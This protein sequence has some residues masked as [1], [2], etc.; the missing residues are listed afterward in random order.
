MA[1][2]SPVEQTLDRLKALRAA[3]SSPEFRKELARALASR[4][5]YLAIKAAELIGELKV[6]DL[7][8]D[9]AAAF[10]RYLKDPTFPDQ[11]CGAKTA[12]AKALLDTGA[13]GP[14]VTDVYVAGIRHFQFDGPPQGGRATDTAGAL[15]GYCGLGLLS[16]RHPD[17][18]TEL[19]D[20][21]LDAEL[22]ARIGAARGLAGSG[23]ADAA[24]VLRLRL[25]MGDPS[26]DV[27]GECMAGLLKLDPLRSV[28]LV[29]GFLSDPR[30]QVRD[31][32]ALALGESRLSEAFAP[33]RR[34][35]EQARDPDSRATLLL[36]VALLRR[37]ESVELLLAELKTVNATGAPGLIEALRIYRLDDAVRAKAT[38]LIAARGDESLK[39]AFEAAFA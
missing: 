15:R 4:T 12:V 10:H 20:L 11:G 26:P 7:G 5:S 18:V 2:H 39:R 19:T 13:D 37:P 16:T 30:S 6:C 9:M 23:R 14:A 31:V 1:K 27:L 38:N 22:P 32:A 3:P 21:L 34:A 35:L 33:L 17:A 24:L 29:A 28:K 25:C 8:P 36:S